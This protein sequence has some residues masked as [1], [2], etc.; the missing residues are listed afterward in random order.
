MK[1]CEKL[2]WQDG[3]SDLNM[4]M[5][6]NLGSEIHCEFWYSEIKSIS[7]SDQMCLTTQCA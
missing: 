2:N 5:C 1:K 3:W 6:W 4:A 7:D